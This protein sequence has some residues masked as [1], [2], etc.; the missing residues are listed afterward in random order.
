MPAVT[1]A[2]KA[3]DLAQVFPSSILSKTAPRVHLS[4]QAIS[5]AELTESFQDLVQGGAANSSADHEQPH[6]PRRH[7][8]A[9]GSGEGLSEKR[10]GVSRPA[11]QSASGDTIATEAPD[12]QVAVRSPLQPPFQAQLPPSPVPDTQVVVPTPPRPVEVDGDVPA[13]D[14]LASNEPRVAIPFAAWPTIQELPAPPTIQSNVKTGVPDGLAD[15]RQNVFPGD[16]EL[17]PEPSLDRA[18]PDEEPLRGSALAVRQAIRGESAAQ[19]RRLPVEG[20]RA[21]QAPMAL[22]APA[23]SSNHGARA[24]QALM[25]LPAPA[26]SS[27]HGAR[28]VQALM[29]L[30]APT[31]SPN[32]GARAVQAP[33]ALPAPAQSPNHEARAVQAPMA[34]PAPPQSSNHGAPGAQ[35]PTVLPAPAQS[36]NHGA[37]AVQAPTALAAPAQS[38]NHGARAVQAPTALAAPAQS[39]NHGARAVQAPMALPAPPQSSNHG[40]PGAQAPT[41]LPAPAQSSNHG[42]RAVQAPTALA[43]PAQSS[44]HGAR[45]VQA[46]TALAAPAQSSNHGARAVQA[47]TALAAPRQSSNHGARAI[48]APTALPAPPQSSNHGARAI[49]APTALPAPR[50]SSNHG[51]RAVQAPMALAAPAQSSNHGARSFEAPSGPE[52][53]AQHTART[54]TP[55][56]P[57]ATVIESLPVRRSLTERPPAESNSIEPAPVQRVG[58]SGFAPQDSRRTEGRTAVRVPDTK[59]LSAVQPPS[60]VKNPP[61]SAA[62]SSRAES[63]NPNFETISG[64]R[65][66]DSTGDASGHASEQ[67]RNSRSGNSV[68]KPRTGEAPPLDKPAGQESAHSIRTQRSEDTGRAPMANSTD[69]SPTRQSKPS[70]PSSLI[71]AP[72]RETSGASV[73]QPDFIGTHEPD[74]TLQAIV[75]RR[76]GVN[77]ASIP[78]LAIAEGLD[79]ESSITDSGISLS[80]SVKSIGNQAGPAFQNSL[81]FETTR[82][83]GVGSVQPASNFSRPTDSGFDQGLSSSDKPIPAEQ[84]VSP[85]LARTASQVAAS[86]GEAYRLHL[87]PKG[88]GSEQLPNI[89]SQSLPSMSVETTTRISTAFP[90]SVDRQIRATSLGRE[91]EAVPPVLT[92]VS[93]RQPHPP[94]SQI[95]IPANLVEDGSKDQPPAGQTK[96]ALRASSAAI[97]ASEGE[98]RVPESPARPS[99]SAPFADADREARPAI[100][101]PVGLFRTAKAN[102]PESF[103]ATSGVEPDG[104]ESATPPR[105]LGG[106]LKGTATAVSTVDGTP[107][108]P[109]TLPATGRR[110]AEQAGPPATAIETATLAKAANRNTLQ[111]Q[112]R[113]E[114]L[115]RVVIRLT[116]RAGLIKAMVRTDGTRSRELLAQQLPALVESL[117]RRGFETRHD[118]F[119][120]GSDARQGFDNND[121]PSRRRQHSQRQ[122]RD[123]RKARPAFRIRLN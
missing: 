73:S 17:A 18:L 104:S 92:R 49:Q 26:Q 25:A 79:G 109:A 61:R 77:T 98:P 58:N 74:E 29:A 50:Q 64:F 52:T 63:P 56:P 13:T 53:V 120:S 103:A 32:H 10:A 21:V 43:A 100:T 101:R 110:P 36:S 95:F 107:Q 119:S 112:T 35:A 60:G 9:V 78:T 70:L 15:S 80:S 47:P 69:L 114:Q 113:D 38:S 72:S 85:A 3:L 40:A 57:V 24:V 84:S 22:P 62:L 12:T 81:A 86:G 4:R 54:S 122:K 19:L 5:G 28:A 11:A 71:S 105:S 39:S 2:P 89:F 27:N 14:T 82:T 59:A 93:D 30:P 123:Q 41:V 94:D 34:L 68:G 117:V 91:S 76:A 111:I 108:R 44:N 48:Q 96:P 16:S 23:Q 20:A 118:G 115:G 83:A 31:Q 42:A 55:L 67:R 8:A 37:R 1:T 65:A 46:P 106:G 88:S 51:A 90:Q 7:S 45:A 116:E 87:I 75:G 121:Q 97:L 33:T 102:L 66:E 99:G 6:T